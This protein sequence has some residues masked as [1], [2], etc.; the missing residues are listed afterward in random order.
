M[1]PV[2]TDWNKMTHLKSLI[3]KLKYQNLGK[4][5]LRGKAAKEKIL[6]GTEEH[7]RSCDGVGM[8]WK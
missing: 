7:G 1:P 8:V 6:S 2:P 5:K 3:L 4:H